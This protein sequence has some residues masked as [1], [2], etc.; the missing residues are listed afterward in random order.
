MQLESL[1]IGQS[2]H[3]ESVGGRGA[4]RQH[5]LDMGVIPGA[6]VTMIKRAPMGD[7]IE[8]RIHDY[9]LTM[10]LEEAKQISILPVESIE[11]KDSSSDE[12]VKTEHPGLGEEGRFHP[13]GTGTP[14]ADDVKLTFALVG[15]QNSG[16][17]TL[18]NQ[19]TGSKQHVGNF[20]GVTVDRKDGVIRG[21]SN[22]VIT[23]LPGIYSMSPYSKEELVSRNFVLEQKP[24]AIINIVDANNIERNLYLTMQ[25]LEMDI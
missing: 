16:K 19:L 11:R 6:S 2:G 18:F 7:P 20:P 12:R 1:K 4:L 9:E 8:V 15:N 14:L 5:L 13:K 25:L 17:T 21:Y 23:D 3:I 22:T 24:K 10:R